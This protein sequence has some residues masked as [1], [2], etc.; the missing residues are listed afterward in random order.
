MLHALGRRDRKGAPD[1]F[2]SRGFAAL[3]K[4]IGTEREHDVY[5][6]VFHREMEESIAAEAVGEWP[7]AQIRATAPS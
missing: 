5:Y 4:R 2:D 7:A 1:T 6:P 3:L